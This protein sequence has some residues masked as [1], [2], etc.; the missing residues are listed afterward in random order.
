MNIFQIS[1]DLLDVFNELEENGGELTDELEAKLTVS[2]ADFKTKVE[3]YTKVIKQAES[4]IELVDKEIKRLQELK[5]SKNN[6]IDRLKKVIA[7]AIEMFGETNKSGNK[8][9]DYGTGKI[10]V[11]NTQKIEVNTDVTDTVVNKLVENFRM[12]YF[13]NTLDVNTE[14]DKEWMLNIINAPDKDEVTNVNIT[15]GDFDNITAKL[16]FDINIADLLK[17]DGYQLMKYILSNGA[18]IKGKSDISKTALKDALQD[19]NSYNP[20]FAEIV[21]NKSIIIK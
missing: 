13:N 4:D 18:A 1:Q 17:G 8:Y 2:Q 14:V 16:S 7:W 5:K 20:T 11:R 15:E 6:S 19:V 3:G 10:T 12:M 21:N 9:Y